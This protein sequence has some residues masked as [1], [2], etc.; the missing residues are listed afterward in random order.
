[1][2]KNHHFNR[3]I[4]ILLLL[5]VMVHGYGQ[6]GLNFQGVARTSNNIIL[7]SQPISLRLSILQGSSTG[8]AEYVET[9]RVTT[10]AQGLFT[11]VIGDTGAISTLGNF[12]TINWRNTP[13]FLKIEMDVSAG[14]NF[15]TMG[16]T[17]FQYVA[18]A[19]YASSVDAENIIGVVPVA[20][21]GT[22]A[23]SLSSFKTSLALNN[24]NNTSDLSKPIS[25]ATQNALDLKL[26]AVD[27]IKFTKQ[28]YADS[29]LLT[30]LKLSD[31]AFML[32]NRI[33]KDTLNLSAR[34]NLKA[35]TA[36]L[37]SGLSLKA[38]TSDVTTSLTSKLNKTDTSYLLQKADTTSL[39]NRIDLKANT[40]DINTSLSLKANTSEVL[41]SLVN[42]VDKVTGRELSTN[43]YTT[44]EKTKLAAITGTNTGDQD[45]SSYATTSALALKAN[46]AD[47]SS[48]LELKVNISDVTTSLLLKEN[49]SNKS[50]AADLGG[51]SPSDILFPTQK[52]VKDYVTANASSGG[53]ADAGITTIKLADGAVN[54]A[55][56]ASGISKSKVGLSNVENISLST[57]SGTNSLTTLGIITSGTWSGTVISI[58]NGGTGALNAASART[59][60]GLAIGTNVMAANATTADITPSTNRNYVTDIQAGILSNTSGTNSGDETASTIKTKLG[61]TTLSGTNTGDQTISLTGDVL[62]TGTGSFTTT[63]N[64]IGGVS[65]STISNFDSRISSNTN[66]ITTNTSDI[67]TLNSNLSAKQTGY[68]NLTSIGT[69]SN[70]TGYLKNN[71]SG[72]FSY[73]TPTTADITPSTNRNYV[74]DIQAGILSNTSGTNSGD[75]T[76]STIKTKLG[77]TTLSGTNTGDQT[78]SLTGDVLGTGTGSFTTT[79]NSIGGVSSSTISNFDSRISSNTNS[80]TTNTSDIA[81]LNSNLSAKQTG[82]SNLTSI[83]TLSNTTG[84]LKN[85]GSGSFSYIT[86]TTADITPSTNRNYVTDAQK[87]GVLSNTTGSNTGDE[88]TSTIKTKLGITDPAISGN[89]N[90]Q[91]Q[92]L[93]SSV[94]SG[95]LLF[96]DLY[97]INTTLFDDKA[98]LSAAQNNFTGDLKAKTYILTNPT[99]TT[100]ST[101][102][103]TIN[104]ATGNVLE[105]LLNVNTTLSFTNP[106]I[107]TYIIKIKQ[108]DTGGRTVTF[109]TIKWADDA[110]PTITAT[111]NRT[112]LVTLIYDGTNYYATCLQNF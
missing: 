41:T 20:R 32:S 50:S 24:V 3:S 58:E 51:I 66:S 52:A 76:A 107:G 38:N 45:L 86:P 65:S 100:A 33:G 14:N 17:Q 81:T 84:Y 23:N 96:K 95:E 30:K 87:S 56:V 6:T 10:N 61:I 40:S 37:I 69:L 91:I 36:D 79:V 46:A 7:A 27:T 28:T 78:I 74:T 47:L 59:N 35:N 26:N 15:I 103:T 85:N 43:D 73:I 63:V 48:G 34:I 82:Y 60:L 64:S 57:W 19:Q 49:A 68:S 53:V 90:D 111:R 12:T 22:G 71:G 104:L 2:K 44:A 25:T 29:A 11:A 108:D 55:K 77:I 88:T 4:F 89:N 62:G 75:E 21:G 54:D 110:V 70:T 42:K 98:S 9:R 92:I 39:S 99:T 93:T 83:G 101:S 5:I 97:D 106:R 102:T 67:A 16:I 1:M 80:I 72:S 8:I 109:P 18:Y 13:K 94:G 105:V 31:T 112:D